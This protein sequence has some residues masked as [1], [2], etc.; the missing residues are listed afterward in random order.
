MKLLW[1]YYNSEKGLRY[2]L[3][4][5]IGSRKNKYCGLE[6]ALVP[7]QEIQT[8]RSSIEELNNLSLDK[9][10]Q[11]IKEKCPIS[12]QKAY[13]ELFIDNSTIYNEYEMGGE[14]G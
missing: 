1:I 9:K 3:L 13:K 4:L 12:F 8:I 10:I 7:D 5:H 6:T 2:L 14:M 11:W